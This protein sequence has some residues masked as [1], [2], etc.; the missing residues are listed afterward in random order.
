MLKRVLSFIFAAALLISAVPPAKAVMPSYL[1]T[2]SYVESRFYQ[3]LLDV[4]L[5]GNYR[6]DL[7]NV[8]L[9]QVGYHESDEGDHSGSGID[10]EQNY[11]EYGYFAGCDGYAWCAAFVSWCARQAAI[12]KKVIAN[13]LVARAPY[14]GVPFFDKAEYTPLPGDII[15]FANEGEE[16]SHVGIVL[17]TADELLYT[18]EGNSQDFTR[19]NAYKYT[20]PYI[21]GYGV[22]AEEEDVSALI[23]RPNLFRMDYDLN[24]GEGERRTQFTVSGA[25]LIIYK[26][27]NDEDSTDD[28]IKTRNL[29]WREGCRLAG[30]YVRRESDGRWLTTDGEWETEL[31]IANKSLERE[32]IPDNARIFPDESWSE[33]DFDRFTLFAAWQNEESGKYEL[34]TAFIYNLDSLGRLNFYRD[35]SEQSWYYADVN[36]MLDAGLFSGVQAHVFAPEARLSRA[37]LISVLWRMAGS[38]AVDY[39]TSYSDV[40]PGDWFASPVCWAEKLGILAPVAGDI[41]EPER[42]VTRAEALGLIYAYSVAAGK[43]ECFGDTVP[44]ELLRRALGFCDMADCPPELIDGVLWALD[45]G[46]VEGSVHGDSKYLSPGAQLDRAQLCAMLNRFLAKTEA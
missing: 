15:F 22:Y 17:C 26:N 42:A 43:A 41:F 28:V 36:A 35:I 38:P 32:I 37:Q 8:A 19:V 10:S 18:V 16:W 6:A 27:Q 25:P 3:S 9:S 14:F 33:Q 20:D 39:P 29:C 40:N 30:W 46:L 4:S 24:G 1:P 31:R 13:S 45:T 23:G 11:T 44:V 2:R 12:P 21:K 34:T 7:V 5:T